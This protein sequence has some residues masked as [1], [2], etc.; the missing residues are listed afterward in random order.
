MS[1]NSANKTYPDPSEL[2]RRKEAQRKNEARRPVSEKMLAVTR[3]RDF[4]RK[5]EDI[6]KA[7]RA[8]R[9]AKQV[10]IEIKTR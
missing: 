6:R 7:N 8:K 10:K 5:L 9:A 1:E 4:E 3:L 2:Y